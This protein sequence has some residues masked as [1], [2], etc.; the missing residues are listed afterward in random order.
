MPTVLLGLVIHADCKGAKK[1]VAY[2]FLLQTFKNFQS[3][4]NLPFLDTNQVKVFIAKHFPLL[5]ENR[6]AQFNFKK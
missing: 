3:I 2:P 4:T 5:L 1:P 6:E